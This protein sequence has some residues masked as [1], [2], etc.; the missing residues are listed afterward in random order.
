M[1]LEKPK[2]YM[3]FYNECVCLYFVLVIIKVMFTGI[4]FEMVKKCVFCTCF[5]C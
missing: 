4:V 1:G 2:F 3:K 5:E